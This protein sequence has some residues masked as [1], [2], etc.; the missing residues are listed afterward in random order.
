M[1]RKTLTAI[2]LLLLLAPPGQA[3]TFTPWG[4]VYEIVRDER[5]L[6]DI[7]T[8][9]AITTEIKAALLKKN[10]KLGLAVKTYCYRGK[11]VLLGQ[12]A[13]EGFKCFAVTTA[14]MASG[15]KGV[16]AHWVAP[17]RQGSTVSDLEIA[18]KIRAE[19][20]G[21]KDISA[22]QVETEVFSGHVFLLGMV[23]SHKDATKA[24]AHAK[25]VSGVRSV[26][27]LLIPHLR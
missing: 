2:A 16:T 14:R 26:T 19:L 22:T 7:S 5:S 25:S 4:A 1:P 10:G 3:R 9:K 24:A 23:R 15:V 27:S 11:V 20:V 21:D 6:A 18:A 12:L 8:D 13:D 17:S